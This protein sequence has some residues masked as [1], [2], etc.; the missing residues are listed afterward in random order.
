MRN[1]HWIAILGWVA[2]VVS[3]AFGG[4]VPS[5]HA[6]A[7]PSA[8]SSLGVPDT[9]H[10][11]GYFPSNAWIAAMLRSHFPNDPARAA[12][13]IAGLSHRV[14]TS[15]PIAGAKP[16]GESFLTEPNW[17]GYFV[18]QRNAFPLVGGC[19]EESPVK[20]VGA[21]HGVDQ[22]E[23]WCGVGG[24][25]STNLIQ[26]G[27]IFN[28]NILWGFYELY[29]AG[30]QKAFSVV[31]GDEVDTIISRVNNTVW[32]IFL[33]DFTHVVSFNENFTFT[34]DNFTADFIIEDS[35][36][37]TTHGLP[38]FGSSRFVGVLWY[39]QS[40]NPRDIPNSQIYYN[41]TLKPSSGHCGSTGALESSHEAFTITYVSC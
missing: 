2:L 30:P 3:L 6:A 16:A 27:S 13:D 7:K 20:Q 14:Y 29:P 24:V 39:D 9:A 37:K 28:S 15:T 19:A 36:W 18:D 33:E 31:N 8:V 4:G 17:G 32:N 10:P 40:G 11:G 23:A 41:V 25:H 5:V 22:L 21:A 1:K 26:A 34:V 35:D 38:N 12:R